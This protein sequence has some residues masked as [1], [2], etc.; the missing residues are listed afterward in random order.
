MIKLLSIGTA[1]CS[2]NIRDLPSP[3][4]STKDHPTLKKVLSCGTNWTNTDY[5]NINRSEGNF[6]LKISRP[7]TLYQ[8]FTSTNELGSTIHYI[9]GNKASLFSC[10]CK[11]NFPY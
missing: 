4:S 2:F 5:K 6:G 3:S 9:Q 10:M 11:F 1:V 7:G 8:L